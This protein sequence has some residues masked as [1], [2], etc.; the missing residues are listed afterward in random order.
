MLI[1]PRW[2]FLIGGWTTN[3]LYIPNITKIYFLSILLLMLFNLIINN[4]I[5]EDYTKAILQKFSNNNIHNY[6]SVINWNVV[7]QSS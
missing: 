3:P 6:Y 1:I 7:L 2:N 4:F 5:F